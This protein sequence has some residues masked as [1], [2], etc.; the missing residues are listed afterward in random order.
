MSDSATP[1]DLEQNLGQ[2]NDGAQNYVDSHMDARQMD[3][4][5]MV[6]MSRLPTIDLGRAIILDREV[7]DTETILRVKLEDDPYTRDRRMSNQQNEN[8]PLNQESLPS[9]MVEHRS[10]YGTLERRNSSPSRLHPDSKR[11]SYVDPPSNDNLRNNYDWPPQAPDTTRTSYVIV[12]PAG[13]DPGGTTYIN[14]DPRDDYVRHNYV[15]VDPTRPNGGI[16]PSFMHVERRSSSPPL[17]DNPRTSFVSVRRVS[18]PPVQVQFPRTSFVNQSRGS[19][20]IVDSARPSLSV[21]R[22]KQAAANANANVNGAGNLPPRSPSPGRRVSTNDVSS[23]VLKPTYNSARRSTIGG[24]FSGEKKRSSSPDKSPGRRT[25][26]SDIATPGGEPKYHGR[27]RT[28]TGDINDGKGSPLTARDG[29]RLSRI[30]FAARLGAVVLSWTN[31]TVKSRD[32][33]I[34][35]D[36][37]SGQVHTGF[38]AIM[39]PSGSGKSSLLNTLACRMDKSASVSGKIRLNGK[40]YTNADL[41]RMSG[42]VMQDDLLNPHLTV[43]EILWYTVKLKLEPTFTEAEL[44]E[45]VNT[46]VKQMGLDHCRTTVIGSALRKGISGGERKRVAIGMELLT[47]PQL[48]FLDEPTSGLDSV[49][50]LSVCTL[51]RDIADERFCTVVC[52]IHQPQSKI[53]NLFQFLIILKGGKLI[54]Q[55]SAPG[56]LKFFEESG[57]PCPEFTN[58]AD[59]L[60]DVISHTD[61]YS[62]SNEEKLRS[63]FVA[64]PVNLDEGLDRPLQLNR[65]RMPW[66]RQFYVLLN[67]GYKEQ[68]RKKNVVITQLIQSIITALLIGGVF[69]QIGHHQNSTTRRQPVLFFCVI[70]Q[71]VFGALTVINSFPSERVLILRERAAGMYYS[72]AYYM[73]KITAETTCQVL[74]PIVFSMVVYWMV[75]FQHQAR[76]FF[77][78][79][80]F[81]ILCQLSA[82]SLA[83]MTSALCRTTDLSVTVL[84]MLLEV[85]RLFGGFFL[86]PISLPKYFSWLDALSYVKYC[87]VAISQ[88]ELHGLQL[89]CLPTELKN[90]VCPITTGQQT[91]NSLGLDYITIGDCAGILIVY[92][93]FSRF[94]AYL[95]IRFI[96][97]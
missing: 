32:G 94:V 92:I 29:K 85:N 96:K 46:V 31:M 21:F 78:F 49:T 70:N 62:I 3:D 45:K 33:K 72:S 4:P 75:G 58:P 93:I 95:G 89:Y 30:P 59:H 54:Y 50:A 35:L 67:R 13:P 74:S 2:A 88:N 10:S 91:I 23:S 64:S 86:A 69:F 11:T 8:Q 52:T 90:G 60:L 18:S 40:E 42:Y 73:A 15:N 25:S 41:K 44:A 16:R 28:T 97:H 47:S 55:G 77:L 37:L 5:R 14:M 24:N 22:F 65:E 61:K 63:N 57:F 27:R 83:L 34:V 7:S 79:M 1:E 26:T 87:Y 39:G 81:M 20:P 80:F 6:D 53:F 19:P 82:T 17:D 36:D 71:G 9:Q 12:D 38:T 43:D 51:L 76:K 66:H 68:Y 56:V 48:L 84:P